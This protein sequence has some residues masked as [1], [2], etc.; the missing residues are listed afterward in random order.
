MLLYNINQTP[1]LKSKGF[2]INIDYIYCFF[3]ISLPAKLI[4]TNTIP[5]IV[6]AEA[7]RPNKIPTG[8]R[9]IVRPRMKPTT[10][11]YTHLT[12]PTMAVV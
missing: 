5:A 10:V 9:I 12:L 1:H 7:A 11:S 2:K 4:Q 6:Y 8:A 3:T